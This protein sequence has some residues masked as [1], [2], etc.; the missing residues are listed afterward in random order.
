[1]GVVVG[2][3]ILVGIL[4]IVAGWMGSH[5]Y[6]GFT[7]LSRGCEIRHLCYLPAADSNAQFMGNEGRVLAGVES[8]SDCLH[9]G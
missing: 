6:L 9:M 3:S 4:A 7:V 8:Y 5:Q 2:V 1:M